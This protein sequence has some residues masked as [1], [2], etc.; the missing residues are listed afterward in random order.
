MCPQQLSCLIQIPLLNFLQD[1]Q[2]LPGALL[3]GIRQA[4][5]HSLISPNLSCQY[6]NQIFDIIIVAL[7]YDQL[8]K[9]GIY[10]CNSLIRNPPG[11]PVSF[12]LSLEIS[13]ELCNFSRP[14][15]MDR[16]L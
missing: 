3:K 9:S 12:Q 10:L 15:I 6:A 14:D 8:M 4:V 11:S 2:M 7:I 1:A 13:A 5:G 16:G